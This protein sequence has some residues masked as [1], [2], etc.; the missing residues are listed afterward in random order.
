MRNLVRNRNFILISALV[1]GLLWG[2]GA[3]W[4][5]P[6]TL[7]ALAIVMTFSTMGVPESIFRS[8]R[9]L[10]R[11]MMI[12]IVMN[13]FILG[14]VLLLL[15]TVL[16]YD[17]ALRL[18]FILIA[19]VPPAVAVIPFTYFLRG[20]E[21]L[22]LIG[23]AGAYLGALI[24]M[25]LG[26]FLFFGPGFIDPM[27]LVVIMLELILLP[28]IASRL[29]FKIGMA[30]R[31]DSIKG[32]ITN[33][34]FFLLTYTIVGLNRELILNQPLS[35]SPVIDSK[36]TPFTFSG[37]LHCPAQYLFAGMGNRESRR[38]APRPTKGIDQPCPPWYA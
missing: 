28:L 26:A 15:N 17:E 5:E 4:T 24:I 16:I 33:W 10:L 2:K 13:Y 9:G 36:P 3:R 38:T 25:P 34:S 31:L 22:S 30:S 11:P 1:I 18:G 27:K 6:M 35:L 32:P 20:D 14:I 8:L 21:T 7:P 23:T 29:L 19:A 12:G 37:R